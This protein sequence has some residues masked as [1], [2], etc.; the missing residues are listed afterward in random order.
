MMRFSFGK[1]LFPRMPEDQRRHQLRLILASLMVALAVSGII[2]L[3]ML[4]TDQMTK[5]WL[6]R[7]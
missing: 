1:W 6:A 2:V 5:Y 7:L 3:I 4:L